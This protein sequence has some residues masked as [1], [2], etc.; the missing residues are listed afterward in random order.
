VAS[1]NEAAALRRRRGGGSKRP[2]T[3]CFV[4]QRIPPDAGKALRADPRG[5]RRIALGGGPDQ[6]G[7]RGEI[8]ALRASGFDAYLVRPSGAPRCSAL[9]A[10]SSGRRAASTWTRAIPARRAPKSGGGR[11][12]ASDILLAEDNE[13]NALRP[14]VLEGLG[15]SVTEVGDGLALR[16]GG[17]GLRRRA[18][19]P[20]CFMEPAH[21][22]PLDGL[23]EGA[24]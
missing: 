13:I 12:G 8:A 7:R 20:W 19:R 10:R 22:A 15:H 6:P 9:P 11:N 2:I 21:A 23:A 4:D 5:G 17:T 18:F 14:A 1:A 16:S 24:G 3:P